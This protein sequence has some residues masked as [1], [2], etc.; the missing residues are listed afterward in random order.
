VRITATDAAGAVSQ[1]EFPVLIDRPLPREARDVVV[2]DDSHF[3][4][5][6]SATRFRNSEGTYQSHQD[7]NGDGQNSGVRRHYAFSSHDGVENWTTPLTPAGALGV[8]G[9]TVYGGI[10]AERNETAT[11]SLAFTNDSGFTTSGRLKVR[12]QNEMQARLDAAIF[13]TE[14]DFEGL[15]TGVSAYLGPRARMAI[16]K[17][18]TFDA[19]GQVRWLVRA[20]DQFYVSQR[21]VRNTDAERSFSGTALA[22]GLWAAYHPAAPY[23]LDFDADAADFSHSSLDLGPIQAVG[24]YLDSDNFNSRRASMEIGSFVFTAEVGTAGRSGPVITFADVAGIQSGQPIE[25]AAAVAVDAAATGP[26]LAWTVISGP[27][28][29][30]FSNDTANTTTATADIAGGYTVRLLVNDGGMIAFRDLTFDVLPTP[31]EAWANAHFGALAGS[32]SAAPLADFDG[33]GLSNLEEFAFRTDPTDASAGYR[34]MLATEMAG[35]DHFVT[36]TYRQ[37]SGGSGTIGLDYAADGVRYT[38][39]H[40][41]TLAADGWQAGGFEVVTLSPTDGDGMQTVTLRLTLP[42]VA[43]QPRFVRLVIIAQP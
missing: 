37:R 19:L 36:L 22:N 34:P 20:G 29:L 15:G 40:S 6:W 26:A 16:G 42:V 14:A 35:D 10:M 3:G 11:S 9:A 31:I 33:N 18:E 28:A 30:K 23:A 41:T 25:L 1:L 8:R 4:A 32:P 43:A 13:W 38:A 27:G 5:A 21:L 7:V 17:V 39:L 12:F 2:F 24:L